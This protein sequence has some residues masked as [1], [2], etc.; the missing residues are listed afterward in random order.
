MLGEER[1][2][3]REL[4]HERDRRYS[5]VG[6]ER[7][8]ALKIKDE[9]DRRALE[10]AREI[11]ALKD[12]QANRLREQISSERGLYATH[13]ELK[14]LEEKLEA[15]LGPLISLAAGI[16][17][18]DRGVGLSWQVLVAA[19]LVAGAITAMVFHH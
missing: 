3:R 5:E 2:L 8:K 9:A 14:S 6:L 12:E 18:R 19:I 17:G 15:K 1:R 4:A 11:Q 10:L 13:L 16:A 7:E